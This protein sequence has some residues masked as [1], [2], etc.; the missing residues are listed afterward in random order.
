[1]VSMRI[2]IGDYEI[3][4]W[5]DNMIFKKSCWIKTDHKKWKRKKF[6]NESIEPKNVLAVFSMCVGTLKSKPNLRY[7]LWQFIEKLK[8]V[9]VMFDNVIFK[10]MFFKYIGTYHSN[11][12]YSCVCVRTE[13]K[14]NFKQKIYTFLDFI[15]VIFTICTW[16][17]YINNFWCL[18]E[19][20]ISS[21][22][23]FYILSET[24]KFYQQIVIFILN[25]Y[26]NYV[27]KIG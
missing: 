25:V 17:L 1:M 5:Y 6:N 27:Y 19:V 13:K 11:I 15:D 2:G 18:Y 9:E 7:K 23:W 22:T 20:R 21:W 12:K 14:G 8:K 24:N 16:A 4:K 26:C 10:V 3:F